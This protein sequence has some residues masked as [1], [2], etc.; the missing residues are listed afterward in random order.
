MAILAGLF[1]L[2]GKKDLRHGR[3]LKW[4]LTHTQ[5]VDEMPNVQRYEVGLLVTTVPRLDLLNRLED[6]RDAF[7]QT[8]FR[9][10]AAA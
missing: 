8:L 5:D 10:R 6:E 4:C 9:Y 3:Y 1:G 2:F 7:R